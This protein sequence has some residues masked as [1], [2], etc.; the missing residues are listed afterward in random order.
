MAAG[1]TKVIEF[2]TV[3]DQRVHMVMKSKEEE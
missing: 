1:T 2:T 3:L